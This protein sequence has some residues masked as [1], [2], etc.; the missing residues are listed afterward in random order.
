MA[1]IE[2]VWQLAANP[3]VKFAHGD[4]NDK[5][6]LQNMIVTYNG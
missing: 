5:D 1:G 4:P 2:M 6:L 3:D